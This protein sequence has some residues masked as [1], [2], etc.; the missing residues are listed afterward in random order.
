MGKGK[1]LLKNKKARSKGSKRKS[2]NLKGGPPNLKKR[3]LFALIIIVIASIVYLGYLFIYQAEKCENLSCF[4]EALETCK[5][6]FFI[7]EDPSAVW[8]YEVLNGKDNTCNI[9]VVL[10]KMSEGEIVVEDLQGKSMV[11]E[12]HKGGDKFP[13]KDMLRCSGVLREELQEILIQRMHNYL[14]KN[15]GEIKKSFEVV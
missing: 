8:R 4:Q 5:K 9:E 15:I 1:I 12:V 3:L 13:E 2:K 6:V 10:L 7:R 11:C 14:L